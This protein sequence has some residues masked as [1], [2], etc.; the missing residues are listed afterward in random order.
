MRLGPIVD[1]VHQQVAA[2]LPSG[3]VTALAEVLPASSIRV[4]LQPE[5]RGK[6]GFDQATP[7]GQQPVMVR[8]G[9]RDDYVSE[10]GLESAASDPFDLRV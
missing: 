8:N 4:L 9:S 5:H 3:D 7:E 6:T 1:V 10:G 2:A